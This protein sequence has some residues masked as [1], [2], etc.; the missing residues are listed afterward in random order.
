MYCKFSIRNNQI[1]TTALLNFLS[2]LFFYHLVLF[3]NYINFFFWFGLVL[4][5]YNLFDL[6]SVLLSMGTLE[7]KTFKVLLT[8]WGLSKINVRVC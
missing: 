7:L 1:I 6:I 2:Y 4:Q 8:K 5:N 3:K